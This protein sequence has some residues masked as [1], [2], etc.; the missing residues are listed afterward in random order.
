[1]RGGGEAERKGA[2][3]AEREREREREESARLC[4]ADQHRP[5]REKAARP[6]PN[7]YPDRDPIGVIRVR[8]RAVARGVDRT[9][10]QMG[11]RADLAAHELV[12]LRAAVAHHLPRKRGGGLG[13][14]GAR[15]RGRAL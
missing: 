15:G 2:A 3:E 13:A 11:A 8:A 9:G 4:G 14:R 6:N 7:P 1:M 12:G 10:V 5:A